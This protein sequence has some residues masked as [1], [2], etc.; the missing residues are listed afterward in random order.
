MRRCIAGD[1]GAVNGGRATWAD[2]DI[3]RGGM[4]EGLCG[5]RVVDAQRSARATARGVEFGSSIRVGR[6]AVGAMSCDAGGAEWSVA[7][8]AEI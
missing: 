4:I 1:A 7:V 8:V 2:G 5:L 6:V 3:G